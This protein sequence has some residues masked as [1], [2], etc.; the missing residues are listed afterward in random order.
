MYHDLRA[1]T[2]LYE[3]P[4]VSS[5]FTALYAIGATE[6][7]QVYGT[8]STAGETYDDEITAL[9]DWV[10]YSR[11][12]FIPYDTDDIE[13]F[14][15]SIS[16]DDT[17][18][19]FSTETNYFCCTDEDYIIASIAAVKELDSGSYKM[20]VQHYVTVDGVTIYAYQNEVDEFTS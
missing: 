12:L 10:T 14:Y 9:D 16:G 3:Q 17:G 2:H 4:D 18:F 7:I 15:Y 11:M 13:D 19:T 6:E 8:L 20:L 5:A 1:Q